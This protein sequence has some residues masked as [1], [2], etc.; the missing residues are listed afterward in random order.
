VLSAQHATALA[1]ERARIARD[2]HDEL[3]S[4]LTALAMRT[5]LAGREL[6]GN[7]PRNWASLAD[8]SRALAER[9][10]DVIWAVDPECDLLEALAARLAAD[11][12][13]FLVTAG[14][15][16]RLEIPEALPNLSI[17][18]EARHHLSMVAKE[19]LHNVVKYSHASEVR[20]GLDVATGQLKMLISANGVGF[21]SESEQ[22]HGFAN[23]R[24]RIQ[25]LGGNLQIDSR[26]GKGVTIR[27]DVPVA[28]LN[29]TKPAL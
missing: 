9:M 28:R 1:E 24:A 8:E 16:L 17:S 7:A 13:N 23:M 10:R 6:N 27:A 15:R 14:I 11:A 2:L 19:A 4:R 25:S 20:L 12:E 22:G 5:E 21:Q 3:G 29:R 18:A 26:P